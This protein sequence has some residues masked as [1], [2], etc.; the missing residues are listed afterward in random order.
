M[1]KP[2]IYRHF[3]GSLMEVV[4]IA[5]HSETLEDL[6][7]YTHL[8]E[9]SGHKWV[10][11]L[12]MFLE[13][14]R[15]NGQNVPRFDY[16]GTSE[17]EAIKRFSEMQAKKNSSQCEVFEYDYPSSAFS[18]A[19]AKINGRY[20]ESGESL[21]ELSSQMYYLISGE[22]SIFTKSGEIKL[23]PKDGYL[24]SAGE[25]YYTLANNAEVVLV[26]TPAWCEDQYKH[27]D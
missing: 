20:P 3:K 27:F 23:L 21:N 6:V 22:L 16:V 25:K 1:I 11:P 5:R 10:R 12:A 4:G 8:D 18:F 24:L 9:K 17:S 14:V 15:V 2:G 26:N 19:T 13:N 7:I